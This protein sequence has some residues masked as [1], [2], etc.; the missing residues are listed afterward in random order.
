M[1]EEKDPLNFTVTVSIEPTFLWIKAIGPYSLSNIEKLFQTAVDQTLIL[2]KN[3][4]LIDV[5]GVTGTIPLM[6]RFYFA[7]SISVYITE[8]AL[9]KISRVAVLGQEPIIDQ[10]RFGETVAVNRGI[11]AKVF[12]NR[13]EALAWIS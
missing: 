6:E 3:K 9:G 4:I 2:Q 10:D 13:V 5:N 8:T 7:E 12:T 11:N 1:T